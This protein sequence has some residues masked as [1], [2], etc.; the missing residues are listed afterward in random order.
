LYFVFEYLGNGSLAEIIQQSVLKKE[1]LTLDQ[2]RTYAA[3]LAS[4]IEYLHK[5]LKV[6]HRDLKPQNV[7]LD[8]NLNLKVIDFGD[9]KQMKEEDS[10]FS[11]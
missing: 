5:E 4:V 7:L 3:Q 1:P 9:A 11:A 6:I 2:I 8:D 10:S